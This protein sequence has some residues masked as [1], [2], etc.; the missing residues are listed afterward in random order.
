MRRRDFI[1][2]LGGAASLPIAARGQ[3]RSMPVIGHLALSA[4][5]WPTSKRYLAQFL[6]GL[7]QAGFSEGRNVAIEYRW[8]RGDQDHLPQL[9]AELT[10]RGVAVIYAAT[11]E[12]AL[13]AKAATTT[14]PIVFATA[15]DPVEMGLVA[16]LNRPGGNMT[17]TSAL[18]IETAGKMLEMLHEAAPKARLAAA[19][20]NPRSALHEIFTREWAEAARVLGL[21]FRVFEAANPSEIDAVLAMLAQLPAPLL[22]IQGDTFLVSRLQQ[23]AL[24]SARHGIPAIFPLRD[25]P[26]AGGLMSYG[27]IFSEAS[28]IAGGYVGR[29][30]KGEKPADLPVQRVTR[31]ELIINMNAAKAIGMNFPITLLGRAD[32]VIE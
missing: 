29:I 16:S 5:G 1:V 30:L 18:G 12:P 2:A 10:R 15:G 8:A 13:A 19:L 20:V 6:E 32:E 21:E 9:A 31:V 28:R 22:L 23:I 3:Q 27:C 7:S 25:F 26:D 4:P 14:V 11:S 24:L 17:G